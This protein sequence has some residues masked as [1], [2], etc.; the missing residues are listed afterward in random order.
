MS[1]LSHSPLSL[2]VVQ[3]ILLVTAA[4]LLGLLTRWMGQPM[5]VAEI[6]A[7]IILGPSLLGV[8]S[9]STLH[10]LFPPSS[11][12]GLDLVSQLGLVLFMFLVGLELDPKLL[13]GRG[14]S[15]VVISH[16]SI[17]VPFGLGALAALFLYPRLSSPSVPFV[18]FVLFLGTAMSIT[19]FPVLARMLTDRHLLGTKLGSIA[20]T[21]AA[22]DDVTAWCLLAFVVSVARATG[23]ASALWTTGFAVS[24]ILVMLLGVRPFLNRLSKRVA[25][26]EGLNQ[27]LV[28]LVLVLLLAS[29][30]VAD[31][32]GIHA[33]FGAFIFGATLP[34][35]GGLAR[36]LAEKLED[37]VVVLLLPLFFAYSGLR[38]QIGLLNTPGAWGMTGLLIL[39]ASVGKF[40]GGALA[41]KLTK[42]SWKESSAIGLLMNTRGLVE[43]IVLNVGLDLGVLSPTLFTML[44]LMALVTTF[45]TSPLL[46]W[47]LGPD[48]SGWGLPETAEAPLAARP[49]TVLMCVADARSGP[50]MVHFAQ[51]VAG[52]ARR[53][54][55]LWL[56]PSGERPSSQLNRAARPEDGDVLA[57]L[58][59]RA[60]EDSLEVKPISFLSADPA[61]DICSV[62]EAKHADLILLGLHRP[63]LSRAV[64]G[65][66]VH[67]VMREATVP[68]AVLVDRGLG[69]IRRVLVPF[70]GSE[71]DLAALRLAQR[72]ATQLSATLTVLTVTPPER[73]GQAASILGRSVEK[74]KL[75]ATFK[76]VHASDP[77]E[78]ALAEARQ[79]YG[80]MVVGIGEVWGLEHRSFGLQPERLIRE[81]PVSMVVV[82]QPDAVLA[83]ADAP[84]EVPS[85]AGLPTA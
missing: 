78:A 55:A 76:T 8:I 31:A 20:I 64:L 3:A 2:L 33:L 5:V 1:A 13:K 52:Q 68:V 43:L 50:G 29:A 67:A 48:A 14:H 11:M 37:L 85:M 45:A 71:H 84:Q 42:L 46:R 72:L 44:V 74:T 21:C 57:P 12:G 26:R 28:A 25:S 32:I 70:H 73:A 6:V 41:A 35:E 17:L 75:D 34:K 54:L 18:S 23:I 59:E 15:S 62:A 16:S 58:L 51:R 27:N 19:A 40:G 69:E 7:G 9:P 10:T 4:R 30:W 81:S 61:R 53:L 80:L 22:V 66:T 56:M 82:R 39:V 65:G 24:F 47:L 38:T 77:V 79:G 60:K 36:S 49:F 83:P 63:L